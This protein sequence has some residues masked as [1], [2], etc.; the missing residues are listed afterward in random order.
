MFSFDANCQ[1]VTAL[2]QL[3]SATAP[4]SHGVKVLDSSNR[5]HLYIRPLGVST[6]SIGLLVLFI[7]T[8][9]VCSGPQV[10]PIED[11]SRCSTILHHSSSTYKRPLSRCSSGNRFHRN[12]VDS[13]CDADVCNS[14]CWKDKTEVKAEGESALNVHF[15]ESVYIVYYIFSR[16]D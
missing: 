16:T 13:P 3:F 11:L 1:H 9:L 15:Q 5:L 10:I 8:Y 2:V 6:I 12:S 14:S 4:L 7:G